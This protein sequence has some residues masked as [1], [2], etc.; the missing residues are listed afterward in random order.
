LEV[1]EYLESYQKEFE[2]YPV[3]NTEAISIKK[4]GDHW[5]SLTTN[6]SFR[7]KFVIM[8][9]GAFGTP[10]PVDFKGADNF[11]GAIVHSYDYKTGKDFS[12][13]NVLVIGF[14]NSA[15]EIAIDLYEHG[16]YPTMSVRSAVNV[17]PR[18]IAGVPVLELS[19][20]MKHLSPRLADTINAPLI[21]LTIGDLARLGLKK[22]KYGPLEQFRRDGHPPVL[23]IGTIHHIRKGHIK[24]NDD[25]ERIVGRT[26]YFKN[27]KCQDFDA[28]IAAIGYQRN[29]VGLLQVDQRRFEDLRAPTSKQKYFGDDGLYF[30]G[31]WISPVGQIREIA[32]DAKKIAED[33]AR[34][35][36]N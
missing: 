20:L 33:I 2:I 10:K 22:N 26:V 3:L 4:D 19:F 15:C 30:C 36:K 27:G 23:D 34:K 6:G 18:D 28:I 29:Y 35:N 8:A 31:Y 1:L 9:T 11:R 5:L 21:R 25:I 7:S 12:D 13:Q 16:A 14:G 24:I 17:V 32:L